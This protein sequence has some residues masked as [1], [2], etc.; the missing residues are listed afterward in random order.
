MSALNKKL[1]VINLFGAPG[2]GKSTTAALVFARLKQQGELVELVT[3]YAKDLVWSERHTMFKKQDYIFA[4][5]HD[6]VARLAGKVNVAVTDSP[7]L[8]GLFYV[9][10][11]Y[12]KTFAPFCFDV[13][14][15]FNNI[16]I[17]LHRVKPYVKVGRNQE[18]HESDALAVKIREMLHSWPI[19]RVV[20]MDADEKA[21]DKILTLYDLEKVK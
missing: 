7:L 2:T 20:E 5:Q 4:K 16:N 6:K 3:E 21:V 11:E 15:S 19:G 1:T 14:N 9:E 13:F 10:P 8:T 18:E 12:P 17:F